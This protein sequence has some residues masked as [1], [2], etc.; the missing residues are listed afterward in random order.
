MAYSDA[1]REPIIQEAL[2]QEA[3]K[4]PYQPPNMR[5]KSL[6]YSATSGERKSPRREMP[7]L[8]LSPLQLQEQGSEPNTE[9]MGWE[10]CQDTIAAPCSGFNLGIQ[11]REQIVAEDVCHYSFFRR[12]GP[13]TPFAD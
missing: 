9:S 13:R 7:K 4:R 10:A 12:E 11:P 2:K 3:L 8:K 5:A 1:L 6:A